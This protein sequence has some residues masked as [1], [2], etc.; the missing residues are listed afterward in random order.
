MNVP[1]TSILTS[2][3]VPQVANTL[4]GFTMNQR[5]RDDGEGD[6]DVVDDAADVGTDVKGCRSG[7]DVDGGRSGDRQPGDHFADGSDVKNIFF[8]PTS[9]SSRLLLPDFFLSL[10]SARAAVQQR[11]RRLKWPKNARDER[12]NQTAL[13]AVIPKVATGERN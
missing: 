7:K 12:E 3:N 11:K 10:C 1:K 6:A 2:E 5:G 4:Q 9:S 8:F 13:L